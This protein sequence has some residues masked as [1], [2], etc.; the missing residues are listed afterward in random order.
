MEDPS[1]YGLVFYG[2]RAHEQLRYFTN[3]EVISPEDEHP[4][5]QFTFLDGTVGIVKADFMKGRRG[6]ESR[7]YEARE[8]IRR[9]PKGIEGGLNEDH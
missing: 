9:Y 7:W 3:Y 8:S 6:E 2:G 1:K 5:I 4:S